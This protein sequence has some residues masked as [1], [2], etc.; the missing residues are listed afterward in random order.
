VFSNVTEVNFDS[1]DEGDEEEISDLDYFD[2]GS[3]EWNENH[4]ARNNPFFR[5]WPVSTSSGSVSKSVAE[6]SSESACAEFDDVD[7][8]E[9]CNDAF[10]ASGDTSTSTGRP[11][12]HVSN[13]TR[14]GD[15]DFSD[16]RSRNWW[17]YD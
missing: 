11:R 9:S 17:K 7:S 16:M 14:F 5:L 3:I 2:V 6:T 8:P 4:P 12:R 1:P 10:M 13:T 15:Y